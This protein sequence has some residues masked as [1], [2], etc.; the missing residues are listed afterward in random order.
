MNKIEK[1]VSEL[2]KEIGNRTSLE[3][4]LSK[5]IDYIQSLKRQIV[6]SNRKKDLDLIHN[7][8]RELI[9]SGEIS[10]LGK[11]MKTIDD[12]KMFVFDFIT[13]LKTEMNFSKDEI[14]SILELWDMI[15]PKEFEKTES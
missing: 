2:K 13:T 6:E 3:L 8:L 14:S 7:K 12:L 5:T 1:L 9:S 4:E 15:N 10:L 11:T